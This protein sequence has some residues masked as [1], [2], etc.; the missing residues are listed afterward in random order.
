MF[1]GGHGLVVNPSYS[2]GGSS[3][4]GGG[5]P[6][7]TVLTIDEDAPLTLKVHQRN[8]DDEA[9]IAISGTYTGGLPEVIKARFVPRSGSGIDTGEVTIDASLAGGN[10]SGS[11]TVTAGFYDLTVTAYNGLTGIGTATVEKIGVGDVFIVAGQSNFANQ[12][13]S[14]RTVTSER[15]IKTDL[16]G[17]WA[18]GSDPQP[19]ASGTDGSPWPAFMDALTALTGYPV[20]VYDV[21][22][23][24]TDVGDWQP[25]QANYNNKLRVAVQDFVEDGF[26]AVLWGQGESDSVQV[27]TQ[28]YYYDALVTIIDATRTDA[29]WDVPWGICTTMTFNDTEPMQSQANI[30]AAQVQASGYTNCFPGANT[31]DLLGATYRVDD[32]HF[33]NLGL[34]TCGQRWA[35]AVADW[36]GL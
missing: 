13:Q 36:M 21:A 15:S 35:S 34:T 4:Q 28:A 14:A 2:G 30:Q 20:A 16:T 19:S 32:V 18:V 1:Y 8:E 22:Q 29:N 9:T 31:D 11:M 12:G 17:A 10:Y 23:G 7:P 26:R 24:S 3:S 25:G 27:E 6:D 5:P 33:T